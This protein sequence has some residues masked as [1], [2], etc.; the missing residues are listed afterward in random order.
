ML[1]S[2]LLSS[3]VLTLALAG[4]RREHKQAS[5]PARK[6]APDFALKDPDGRVVRLSDYRG[7]V[8]LL[9]FW[10]TWCAPCRIE[11]PWFVEFER[12]L[13]D[14][15]FAVI[16]VS[17]DEGGWDDVKAFMA[18]KG[19]NYRIVMGDDEVAHA[20]GG[21]ESLPTTF[22]IDRDGKVAATHLGLVSK[23][24]YEDDLEKLLGSSVTAG[25][26]GPGHVG[27]R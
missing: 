16:G 25:I 19:I 8:V 2:I 11:I 14:R 23:S 10:A 18:G 13:K 7:K 15:G 24:K 5:D 1:R 27:A 12:R 9:N 21:V 4:C 17:M 20:Y 26:S 6:P 22:I 3:L